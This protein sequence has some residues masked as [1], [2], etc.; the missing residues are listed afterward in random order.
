MNQEMRNKLGINLE[1]TGFQL[2]EILTVGSKIFFQTHFYPL[3]KMQDQVR[4]LYL[5]FRSPDGPVPVLLNATVKPAQVGAVI[6]CGG[7]EISNR[8]R[9][10]QELLEA[11]KVAADA[12]SENTELN[13]LKDEL[14]NNHHILESQ[15]KQLSSLKDQQK[16]LFKLIAHD[17]QEPLRKSIFFC[18]YLLTESKDLPDGLRGKLDKIIKF[19]SEIREMILT[20]QRFH[21][22]DNRAVNYSDI[23]IDSLISDIRLEL[24][25]AERTDVQLIYTSS[26]IHFSADKHMIRNLF[27]ELLRYSLRNVRTESDALVIQIEVTEL[28]QNLFSKSENYKYEKFIKITYKDNGT[29]FDRDQKMFKIIQR[30]EQFNQID[31]GLAYCKA[32]VEKHWGSII[33]KSQKGE[34]MGITIFMPL[35]K[36]TG[37]V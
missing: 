33:A 23:N 10:E 4:E 36:P 13:K 6:W 26:S 3:V 11:K 12:L 16:E 7:M 22:L 37:F 34:G 9:F 8:S 20:L 30:S 29:G 31:L 5:S 24:K 14:I 2:E 17:L 32:I 21:E 19:N 25:L 15:F 27:R 18:H 35:A 1:K 28:Y